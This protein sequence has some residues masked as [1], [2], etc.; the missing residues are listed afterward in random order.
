MV[1]ASGGVGIAGASG[2][3]GIADTLGGAGVAGTC[4]FVSIFA[5]LAQYSPRCAGCTVLGC[6]RHAGAVSLCYQ[7][8][9]DEFF[10]T[11]LVSVLLLAAGVGFLLL[12]CLFLMEKMF[13]C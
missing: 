9:L 6:C 1:D 2:G 3:V 4:S 10:Q 11:L 8:V 7:K 5:L 12:G 13:Y